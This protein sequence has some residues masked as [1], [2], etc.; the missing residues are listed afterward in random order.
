MS[1]EV[2]VADPSL[3]NLRKKKAALCAASENTHKPLL[4]ATLLI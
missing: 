1:K 2:R 3:R 4:E